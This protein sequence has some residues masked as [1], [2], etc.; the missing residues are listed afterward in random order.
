MAAA[1][2]P[3]PGWEVSY[4]HCILLVYLVFLLDKIA[5]LSILFILFLV[6]TVILLL[7]LSLFKIILLYFGYM[8]DVHKVCA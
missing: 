5:T 4:A 6:Y 3:E 8:V 1:L 7:H 2:G